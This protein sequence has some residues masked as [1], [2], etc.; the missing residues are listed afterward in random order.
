MPPQH[1]T[2]YALPENRLKYIGYI[3]Y[4]N[5]VPSLNSVK[6]LKVS[7]LSVFC[8]T[9]CWPAVRPTN[10]RGIASYPIASCIVIDSYNYSLS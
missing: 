5:I 7:N 4:D 2:Q 3:H 9:A 10:T 8:L 1:A 6:I